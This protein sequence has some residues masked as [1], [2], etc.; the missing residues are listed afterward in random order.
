[1]LRLFNGKELKYSAE[2]LFNQYKKP[3]LLLNFSSRLQFNKIVGTLGFGDGISLEILLDKN[4]SLY[5]MVQQK[6]LRSGDFL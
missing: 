1:M 5:K 4:Q 2:V 6:P 3:I